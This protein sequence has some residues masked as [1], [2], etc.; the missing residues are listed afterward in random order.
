MSRAHSIF[1][2]VVLL[3][4]LLL[5]AATSHARPVSLA[6]ASTAP[7]YLVYLWPHASVT[8]ASGHAGYNCRGGGWFSDVSAYTWRGAA[9]G[10][11]HWNRAHD[12][13]YWRTRNGRVTFD[14]ITFYNAS[15][16][17]VL[18]AGWCE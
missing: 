7:T 3:T 10:A 17:P 18:V 9:V 14:G 16:S 1:S 12:L 2:G 15:R 11:Q 13:I 5:C 8:Y 4:A 6:D